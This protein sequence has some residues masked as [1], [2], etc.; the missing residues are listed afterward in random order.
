MLIAIKVLTI[1]LV[2][3]VCTLLAS[4]TIKHFKHKR[5]IYA[6][7]GCNLTICVVYYGFHVLM[8]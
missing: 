3:I 2:I 1:I 8:L 5:Y 7:L 6:S 4:D